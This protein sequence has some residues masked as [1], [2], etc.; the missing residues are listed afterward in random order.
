M[1]KFVIVIFP[2]HMYGLDRLLVNQQVRTCWKRTTPDPLFLAIILVNAWRCAALSAFQTLRVQ[3]WV[4]PDTT[5]GRYRAKLLI[6][7]GLSKHNDGDVLGARA[8]MEGARR[9]LYTS[10]DFKSG[11]GP[12][13]KHGL[14]NIWVNMWDDISLSI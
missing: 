1:V 3:V 9:I 5:L 11:T 7:V 10:G 6:M 2:N 4:G 8:S 13:S 12:R 14:H